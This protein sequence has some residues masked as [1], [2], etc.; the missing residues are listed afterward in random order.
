MKSVEEL[1]R[2]C[3]VYLNVIYYIVKLTCYCI[4]NMLQIFTLFSLRKWLDKD[5]Y[6]LV[7]LLTL[8]IM[9]LLVDGQLNGQCISLRHCIRCVTGCIQHPVYVT[10][11]CL[12]DSSC[13][14]G[15]RCICY[16]LLWTILRTIQRSF[17]LFF[18]S[19]YMY[20]FIKKNFNTNL[21]S[22]VVLILLVLYYLMS[23]VTLWFCIYDFIEN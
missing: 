4:V 7:F 6:L 14:F 10:G 20:L 22:N 15:F 5:F 23:I 18:F 3:C 17:V 21:S 9:G 2:R 1:C 8:G 19:R 11:T 13:L 12:Q 16:S